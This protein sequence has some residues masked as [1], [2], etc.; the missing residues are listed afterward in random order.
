MVKAGHLTAVDQTVQGNCIF[1]CQME[2]TI[3]KKQKKLGF[4]ELPDSLKGHL[5][6]E[7]SPARELLGNSLLKLGSGVT[8]DRAADMGGGEV[9]PQG[10]AGVFERPPVLS[11][12]STLP[13][14]LLSRSAPGSP[15]CPPPGTGRP[16]CRGPAPPCQGKASSTERLRSEMRTAFQNTKEWACDLLKKHL[17]ASP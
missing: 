5:K 12:R 14:E 15:S 8:G 6:D 13:A 9:L 11:T 3:K 4:K 10:G 1:S 16:A 7:V 2:K 17:K